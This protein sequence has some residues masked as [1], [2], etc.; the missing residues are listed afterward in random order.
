MMVRIFK[1]GTSRGEAPVN[2]L[3]SDVDH[4]GDEREVEPEV[5]EG[6]P[7]TTISVINSISRKHKYVSGVIAF[8]DE[9]KPSR[10]QI[11][12]VIDAFKASV[13]PGLQ[14]EQYNNLWVLHREKGNTELHFVVPMVELTTGRRLN[15]HP[16]GDSNLALYEAFSQVM[17][18]ALGYGQ[19][20]SDPLKLG[21]SDFEHKA[22][23]GADSK[24]QVKGLQQEIKQAI[25]SGTVN[26]REDLCQYL[27]EGL[28]CTITRKGKNY[29]SV[30]LPGQ[31]KAIR[32]RGA[33]FEEG[34]DYQALLSAKSG[35]TGPV[36]L[37]GPEYEQAKAHLQ[38]LVQERATYNQQAYSTHSS[39]QALTPSAPKAQGW[40]VP[41]PRPTA[42]AMP[43]PQ[44]P[45]QQLTKGE[46]VMKKKEQPSQQA[47]Q[48]PTTPRQAIPT[49][50]KPTSM[51]MI[52]MALAIV[53][54]FSP[55]KNAPMPLP[56][57]T[58]V[59]ANI[60]TLRNKAFNANGNN[61]AIAGETIYALECAILEV[62]SAVDEARG[63]LS[64]ART[65]AEQQ[66]ARERLF[67]VEEQLRKLQGELRRVKEGGKRLRV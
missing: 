48:K 6:S 64:S 19:I 30:Q 13:L 35:K 62:V 54:A 10:E 63:A 21:L 27:D 14:P 56:S 67:K 42:G 23:A 2:Y 7:A 29:L 22:P 28:G 9:E 20:V 52:T 34:A 11:Y 41:L 53:R 43:V 66:K 65:P 40:T 4:Q 55:S 26:N 44:I 32:L 17:N 39:R 38:A 15:I 36:L 60:A 24:R 33:L 59:K 50:I 3:L 18:Q 61:S 58:M 46:E 57:K 8:R 45:K 37:T 49:G 51:E 5:L 25:K 12:E 31:K 16:P 1:S 47:E